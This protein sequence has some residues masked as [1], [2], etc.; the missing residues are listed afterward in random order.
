MNELCYFTQIDDE[1]TEEALEELYNDESLVLLLKVGARAEIEDIDDT[2]LTIIY[3]DT[4]KQ[5]GTKSSVAQ[6]LLEI[7][8]EEE[9]GEPKG[10]L[11]EAP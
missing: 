11:L 9:E 10:L 7:E 6:K 1:F 8:E 3:G 5:P 2:M 4:K